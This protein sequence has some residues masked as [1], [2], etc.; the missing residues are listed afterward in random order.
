MVVLERVSN[1]SGTMG[2][3]IVSGILDSI[4]H[5]TDSPLPSSSGTSTPNPLAD[6]PHR[7]PNKFIACVKRDESAHTL[8]HT[9][10]TPV[11]IFCRENVKG[12]RSADLI[13][14]GAKPNMCKEILT[15]E[16]MY[17]AL[18]GK[19][20]ISIATGVTLSQMREWCPES[21]HIVRAMPNVP[22]KIR[23]GMTVLVTEPSITDEEKS[24]VQWIFSQIGRAMFLEEK[25]IDVATALCGSGPAFACVV[26]EAMTDG[27]VMMGIPRAE[28]QILV[29]QS[30]SLKGR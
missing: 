29:A 4:V 15:Q 22:C 24:I 12:A 30:T 27:G 23:Q 19:L 26:L 28:A 18:E 6:I 9:F 5:P 1:H 17:E 14:L 3:A 21:T 2:V 20:L 25:H 10:N 13:L 11:Q 7:M 8:R 16:G